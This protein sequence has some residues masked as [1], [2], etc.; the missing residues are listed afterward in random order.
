MINTHLIHWFI[1]YEEAQGFEDNAWHCPFK[2]WKYM[3]NDVF[4]F[5]RL[6]A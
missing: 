5:I 4:K 1:F 3:E 6:D 2:V